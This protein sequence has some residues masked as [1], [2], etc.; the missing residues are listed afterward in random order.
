MA[1]LL[2][3]ADGTNHTVEFEGTAKDF[4]VEFAILTGQILEHKIVSRET[5]L[6]WVR[7]AEFREILDFMD[8]EATEINFNMKGGKREKKD[9]CNRRRRPVKRRQV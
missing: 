9:T 8:T 6:K 1:H 4:L 2:L 5:F 7:S 3:K